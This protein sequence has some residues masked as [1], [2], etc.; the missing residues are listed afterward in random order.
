M[1]QE[2]LKPNNEKNTLIH[3]T[4]NLKDGT[5]LECRTEIKLEYGS[6]IQKF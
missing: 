6:H 5:L 2:Q 4:K 1:K 3:E